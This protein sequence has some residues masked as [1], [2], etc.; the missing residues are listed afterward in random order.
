VEFRAS[1]EVYQPA[2]SAVDRARRCVAPFLNAAF[3]DS[4]LATFDC[5]LRYV[6]IVMPANM[7]GHYPARSKLRK[8]ERLYDCA[9][10]LDYEIFVQGT[11]EDQLKEYLR[12]IAA[13]ARHLAALGASAQQIEDFKAILAGAVERL[14]IEQTSQTRH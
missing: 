1:A 7:Q 9:P 5:K 8:K 6:P 14:M 10:I 4:S 12:G 2:F 13:S 3:R 11:F